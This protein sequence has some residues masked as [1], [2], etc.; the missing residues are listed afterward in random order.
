MANSVGVIVNGALVTRPGVLSEVDASAMTPTVPGQPGIP[1]MIGCSD[2][3]DPGVVYDFRSYEEAKAVLRGGDILAYLAGVFRPSPDRPGSSRVL[4]IRGN[5]TTARASLTIGTLKVSSVG[6]GAYANGIA[7]TLTEDAAGD[8]E[9]PLNVAGSTLYKPWTLKVDH[10]AD[11]KTYTFRVRA[12]LLVKAGG[13]GTFQ[14]D[15]ANRLVKFLG[16]EATFEEVPTL[17]DV[18]AWASAIPGGVVSVVGRGW[19]PVTVL[20]GSTSTIGASNVFHPANQG[21][22]AYLLNNE[23]A[24]VQVL[25]ADMPASPSTLTAQARALLTGG[26][27]RGVDGLEATGLTRALALADAVP[28]DALWIQSCTPAHQALALAHCAKNCDATQKKW[29]IG[30]Y[31]INWTSTSPLDG[32]TQSGAVVDTS[33]DYACTQ[34]RSLDGPSV[35]CMNGGLVPHPETGIKVQLGGLGFAARLMGMWC[36]VSRAESCSNKPVLADGLEFPLLTNSQVERLLDAGVT[37]AVFDPDQNRTVVELALTC[38]QTANPS[39]RLLHGLSIQHEINRM[40]VRA[41]AKRKGG[42]LS[43]DQGE[44]LK[45]DCESELNRAIYSGQNTRGFLTAGRKAGKAI[46][47]WENLS[48]RGDT[49]TGLWAIGVE[50]HAV[51]EVQFIV[52]QTKLTPVA[53]EI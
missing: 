4:F 20:D 22:V 42:I 7:V 46:P 31:G 49:T 12:G 26:Q 37:V 15:H 35:L 2:G 32:A 11:R 23:C 43:L 44:A 14:V 53:I 40:W 19:L 1:L 25:P 47:A 18:A 17:K 28:V 51:G 41:L 13:A 6:F 27:G 8:A 21:L 3:G 5:Q 33:V 34:A 36:A 50:A 16:Q 48:V 24:I 10:A 30:F 39:Y 52:V 38:Y 9:L 29:R 45:A